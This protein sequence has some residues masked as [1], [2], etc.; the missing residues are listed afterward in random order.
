MDP[1][2]TKA[3]T[4]DLR[5]YLRPLWRRKVLTLAIVT[6][7][8]VATYVHYERMPKLY[9]S[10]TDI[11][12][13]TTG[14]DTL[15]TGSD[16]SLSDRDLQNQARVLRSSAVASRVAADIG[17]SGNPS[18]L[19]NSV[20]VVPNPD[21]D[22]MTLAA[23]ATSADGAARLA[24]GFARAFLAQTL[25][26]NQNDAA[27]A[28]SGARR[29]YANLAA[30]RSPDPQERQQLL[31]QINRLQILQSL[32]TSDVQQLDAA[33]P[34][35]GPFSPQPRRNTIFALVLSLAFATMA[36]YGL[37][38][39]DRR[40]HHVDDVRPIYDAPVIATVPR[41]DTAR[42]PPAALPPSLVEAFRTL[43]TALE[44]AAPVRDGSV[45]ILVT[46]AVARE[47]KSTVVRNLGLAFRE[48]GR[49]VAIVEADLRRPSLARSLFT[50]A[51]PGLTDVLQGRASLSDAMH[52]V[53]TADRPMP[54]GRKPAAPPRPLGAGV[55]VIAYVDTS[56]SGGGSAA[57]EIEQ[58]CAREDWD[59][60]EVVAERGDRRP[61]DRTG[62]AY[63]IGRIERGEANALVVYDLADLGR[64]GVG[65][66][67]LTRRV[68]NTGAAL[69]T[70][71]PG[72]D[73]LIAQGV[74]GRAGTATGETAISGAHGLRPRTA[75]TTPELSTIDIAR[76]GNRPESQ[77]D[78]GIDSPNMTLNGN[79]ATMAGLM[80]IP[81]GS[82][83]SDPPT[84]LGSNEFKVLL[85]E[86]K[87]T[88]DIV[89]IDTT[90]LLEVSDAIPVIAEADSTLIVSR[91][92]K[93]TEGSAVAVADLMRRISGPPIIG[94]VANDVAP[95]ARDRR[96]HP[97]ELLRRGLSFR[98]LDRR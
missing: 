77:G 83:A 52:E 31:D 80:L 76:T 79:G 35:A 95:R 94:V 55:P 10:T 64:R 74:E 28:L 27:Q 9:R 18:A 70:C 62:L 5:D 4:L 92:G 24:N 72:G 59:L 39:I 7:V 38:R 86:L 61:A 66:A 30:Q 25:A 12:L 40:I 98:V 81:S 84:L 60:I 36:A 54:R 29:A 63:A 88:F 37:D 51:S 87:V 8:T 96:P 78:L 6:V 2:A 11:Y 71:V 19:L 16:Q 23:V 49:R 69:V 15:V 41:A 3:P 48:A 26:I 47:G 13:R 46:S 75:A 50:A 44:V 93:T 89:L 45:S 91:V 58:T 85:R 68:R 73:P 20:A 1:T 67:A 21:A 53:V 90:P 65:R 33:Q 57:N 17:Y 82:P 34:P 22:Y 42:K 14:V 56:S 43:R 97:A 32:P